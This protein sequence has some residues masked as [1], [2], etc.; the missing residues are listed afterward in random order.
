MPG[1]PPRREREVAGA[2]IRDSPLRRAIGQHF[3][4]AQACR[5]ESTGITIFR[6]PAKAPQKASEPSRPS[7]ITRF[8]Q[9][10]AQFEEALQYLNK[11]APSRP[12]KQAK[13]TNSLLS[14]FRPQN[15]SQTQV[16][17]LVQTLKET[18]YL[19]IDSNG[20]VSYAA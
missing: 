5:L 12:K 19:N 2:V 13:L 8:P 6:L 15:L 7:N 16:E 9:P 20:A 1:Q 17:T 10:P 4:G 3:Q 18:G 11:L 14:K